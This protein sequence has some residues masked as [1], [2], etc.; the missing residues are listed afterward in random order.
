MKQPALDSNPIQSNRIKITSPRPHP[1]SFLYCWWILAFIG[2]L[3]WKNRHCQIYFIVA[4]FSNFIVYNQCDPIRRAT[5]WQ[6]SRQTT[7]HSIYFVVVVVAANSL[8]NH[9]SIAINKRPYHTST[10]TISLTHT[11]ERRQIAN[12][13]HFLFHSSFPLMPQISDSKSNSCVFS[14]LFVD[15]SMQSIRI[16]WDFV[17]NFIFNIAHASHT[18]I[19]IVIQWCRCGAIIGLHFVPDVLVFVIRIRHKI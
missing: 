12:Q 4:S 1:I 2:R 15:F 3:H 17:F 10:F 19:G 18:Y 14:S 6:A 5:G 11:H 9:T 7:V 13:I 8:Y 16:E